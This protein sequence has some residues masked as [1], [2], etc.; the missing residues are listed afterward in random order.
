MHGKNESVPLRKRLGIVFSPG[1]KC[2]DDKAFIDKHQEE[3]RNLF[4][5][6]DSVRQTVTN[7]VEDLRSDNSIIVGVHVRR[8]DYRTYLGGKYFFDDSVYC[9]F[10]KQLSEMFAQKG[11]ITKFVICSNENVD[12]EFFKG[13]NVYR[14]EGSSFIVDLYT[15]ADCDCILGPPSTYS[16]WAS[17][18]GQKP[19][20]F[21]S[22]KEQP[23]KISDFG[24]V[25]RV[26][27]FE[28]ADTVLFANLAK[29]EKVERI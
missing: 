10:M 6:T 29:Q 18:Y 28:K 4:S 13:L 9:S 17:F 25:K 23:L 1:F 15:L 5:P 16:Q 27:T 2:R 22:D 14:K 24:I 11:L 20:C 7:F 3:L 26:D 12:L 19:L 21:V 8:G